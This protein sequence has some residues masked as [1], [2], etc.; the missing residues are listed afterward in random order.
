MY[1]SCHFGKR[2]SGYLP[3]V[4][5]ITDLTPRP[6]ELHIT[7]EL[8]LR[9]QALEQLITSGLT[10]DSDQASLL[11]TETVHQATRAAQSGSLNATSALAQL[12]RSSVGSGI[13][14]MTSE[15]QSILLMDVLQQ[16]SGQGKARDSENFGQEPEEGQSAWSTVPKAIAVG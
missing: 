8:R 6:T 13:G 10:L 3:R 14:G 9:V 15:A 2:K 1:P 16:L 4:T 5:A 11:A 12:T 7:Q